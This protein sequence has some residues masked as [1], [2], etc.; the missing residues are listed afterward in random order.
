MT[1]VRPRKVKWLSTV[2]Y[3]E[4][5]RTGVAKQESEK[6]ASW[7]RIVAIQTTVIWTE[8]TG[9]MT[10]KKNNGEICPW[11]QAQKE[12][13]P[14]LK[15]AR[16]T[17]EIFWFCLSILV[18]KG[19][20]HGHVYWPKKKSKALN[21]EYIMHKAWSYMRHKMKDQDSMGNFFFPW[22]SIVRNNEQKKQGMLI[23][24]GKRGKTGYVNKN[25]HD[26]SFYNLWPTQWGHLSREVKL[27]GTQEDHEYCDGKGRKRSGSLAALRIQLTWEISYSTM[28]SYAILS[29]KE[30]A[31]VPG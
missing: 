12:M 19:V 1:R 6:K 5:G 10:A 28:R 24:M 26:H 17:K 29:H 22:D 9:K 7:R 25:A 11:R 20:R 30:R 18:F 13:G 8:E 31:C 16:G 15:I 23:I 27:L 3:P 21:G 4:C 2:T 14:K